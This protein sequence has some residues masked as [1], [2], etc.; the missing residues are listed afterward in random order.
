MAKPPFQ[1]FPKPC[2]QLRRK[3]S[4]ACTYWRHRPEMILGYTQRTPFSGKSTMYGLS[5][6]HTE[7][8]LP[9][10]PA[11]SPHSA[12]DVAT[13]VVSGLCPTHFNL[14]IGPRNLTLRY[15]GHSRGQGSHCPGSHGSTLEIAHGCV[16]RG[17]KRTANLLL[18]VQGRM[19]GL[20]PRV[21]P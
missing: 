5:P 21:L 20:W 10:T 15:P 19:T 9:L 16:P 12:P 8:A 13:I 7:P 11:A 4:N 14:I 3:C 2:H 18:P 6:P 17:P 1:T